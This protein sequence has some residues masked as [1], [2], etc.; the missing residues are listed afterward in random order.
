LETFTRQHELFKEDVLVRTTAA[1]FGWE[2]VIVELGLD[3]K[4]YES[5]ELEAKGFGCDVFNVQNAEKEE[6]LKLLRL[7]NEFEVEIVRDVGTNKW[8]VRAEIVFK[9]N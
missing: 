7:F 9:E 3:S 1:K 2:F 5:D 6:I 4:V 8:M